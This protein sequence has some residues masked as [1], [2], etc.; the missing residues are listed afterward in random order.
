MRKRPGLRSRSR[1]TNISSHSPTP[2]KVTEIGNGHNRFGFLRR[3]NFE[4]CYDSQGA[5]LFDVF[6]IVKS[7]IIQS[8]AW[9]P[10]N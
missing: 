8:I 9:Y 4:M 10:E 1:T 5:V 7:C 2:F 6:K 3:G